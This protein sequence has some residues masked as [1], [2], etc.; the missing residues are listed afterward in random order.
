MATAVQSRQPSRQHVGRNRFR[1]FCFAK[2]FGQ[3]PS[4][5]L[6]YQNEVQ[7]IEMQKINK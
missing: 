7:M 6:V 4:K 5:G 3:W 1:S 2:R